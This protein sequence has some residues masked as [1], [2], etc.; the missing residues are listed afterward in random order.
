MLIYFCLFVRLLQTRNISAFFIV[1][2]NSQKRVIL[3]CSLPDEWNFLL[4]VLVHVFTLHLYFTLNWV[5]IVFEFYKEVFVY[6][7][8]F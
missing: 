6:L 3:L 1:H 2:R 7:F 4:Y 8:I 5:S